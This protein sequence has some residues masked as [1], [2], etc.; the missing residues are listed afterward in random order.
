MLHL[1][2]GLISFNDIKHCF[3]YL[4]ST[5][6]LLS[7]VLNPVE[8]LSYLPHSYPHPKILVCKGTELEL[9]LSGILSMVIRQPSHSDIKHIP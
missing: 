3:H 6:H 4:P 8:R 5:G 9:R 2:S 7:A 1:F